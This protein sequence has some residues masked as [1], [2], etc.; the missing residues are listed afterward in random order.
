MT[1]YKSKHTFKMFNE[2]NRIR[3]IH[4]FKKTE[5]HKRIRITKQF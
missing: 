3:F 4:Q 1:K 5:K 2:S